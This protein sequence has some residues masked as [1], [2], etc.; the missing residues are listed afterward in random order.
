[1]R[2][3]TYDVRIYKTG[4]YTGAKVKTYYVR[5]RTAEKRWKQPFRNSTQAESFRA[6]LVA[7]AR[8]GEAF[9]LST[10]RPVSW[11][12]NANDVSW[13]EFACTYVDLKWKD[14]SAKYRHDIAYALTTAT[15]A[16]YAS[17]RGRP[18]DAELRKALRRWAFNTKQRSTP[19]EDIARVLD[20]LSRNTKPM[21]ALTDSSLARLLLD[22]ATSRLDGT[23]AAPSTARRNRTI[24]ANAMD[25]AVERKLLPTNPIKAVKWTTPKTTHQVD[26]RSV[27]NPRQ[28]RELLA[29][30]REQKPSGKRLAVFFAVMY[31]AA[32]RP[33]EAISLTR[34]DV[35]IPDLL[36]DE[37]TRQ[38][39]E[40][41]DDWAELHFRAPT[42]DAGREWTDDGAQREQ[43]KQL[44][45]RAVHEER[46]VPCPP[47]LTKL[48]REHLKTVGAAPTD[49]LFVG[50]RGGELPTITYRRAWQKARQSAL[51][52]EEA[53]TPLAKRPY[54]LRHA[55]VSTWLNGG[56]PPTQVAQW[57]GHSVEVLLRIYAAC[58]SGQDD[59]AKRR[60]VEA[61]GG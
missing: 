47:P 40:P 46:R 3:T 25:Y 51:T 35:T 2:E 5:W 34:S 15:P 61:L 55:C 4:V 58:L 6:S 23:R 28:A 52:A 8:N 48:L 43:R 9:S 22:T 42:P 17:T 10:G 57:A 14:A 12:R 1:M 49:R 41:V 44:K 21:S 27:I 39:K 60:I 37:D 32:L 16:M 19:P 18:A 36:W 33:E 7:A 50:V 38:W 29:A 26:R 45:H 31:Y 11:Q 53:K 13:Y 54:D 20:W 24:V 56:V 30:V 59:L